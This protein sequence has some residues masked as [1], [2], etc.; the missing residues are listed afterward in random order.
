M[1]SG[2]AVNESGGNASSSRGRIR[3]IGKASDRDCRPL[4]ERYRQSGDAAAREALVE[5]FL[6]LARKLA[7][8]Y[9]PGPEALDDLR[10]VASVGLLKAIDRYDPA[11]GTA[12]SSFAVP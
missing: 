1:G 7:A 10:Q 11:R 4:F 2:F 3:G 8:R 12:F 6:P 9:R 5:R